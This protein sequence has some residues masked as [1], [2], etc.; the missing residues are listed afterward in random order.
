MTAEF[1]LVRGAVSFCRAASP[2]VRSLR[3]LL[4]AAA[5]ICQGVATSLTC[6]AEAAAEE[7]PP[8]AEAGLDGVDE[9]PAAPPAS[10]VPPA[11]ESPASESPATE[12]PAA[13]SPPATA[14][15][16]DP[17]SGQMRLDYLTDDAA[18]MLALRPQGFFG[19]N[20]FRVLDRL[21]NTQGSDFRSPVPVTQIEQLTMVMTRPNPQRPARDTN[22]TSLVFDINIVRAVQPV[23]WDARRKAQRFEMRP[24]EHQG[25]TYFTIPER[26]NVCFWP[27][28][29]RTYVVADEWTTKR[30]I[31]QSPVD[32]A[33][34]PWGDAWGQLDSSALVIAFAP[35]WAVRI[36]K[37]QAQNQPDL[38]LPG[39]MLEGL[40]KDTKSMLC[41]LD[42]PAGIRARLLLSCADD[43]QAKKKL[44]GFKGLIGLARQMSKPKPP[45]KPAP[46][47]EGEDAQQDPPSDAPASRTELTE[48]LLSSAEFE[49][50]GP[51]AL[52]SIQADIKVASAMELLTGTVGGLLGPGVS[53]AATDFRPAP[54]VDPAA[55][56]IPAGVLNSPALVKRRE[57]S[58]QQIAAV[59][60]ALHKYHD[61]TE[62]LPPRVARSP[63]GAPLLSWRVLILPDLGYEAL[64]NEFRLNEPW[65][66]QHNRPLAEKMPREFGGPLAADT[67]PGSPH[68]SIVALY[69]PQ[70]C[71]AAEGP[72]RWSDVTDG[73][74]FTL[75]LAETRGTTV[76]TCPDDVAV[77]EQGQP[78]RRLAG[79]HPGGAVIATAD[80]QPHFLTDAALAELLPAL[81]SIAGGEPITRER[82]GQP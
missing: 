40:L 39:S 3:Q 1:V 62:S 2:L 59:A 32:R 4:V 82:L 15:S 25:K 76:W 16:A 29:D 28:D 73:L 70:T 65:D 31:E 46:D 12:P 50:R 22:G 17:A 8:A 36:I 52:V 71:F 19:P 37:E 30:I 10:A 58:K 45:A 61:R 49:Q 7:S 35:E 43:A 42:A 77:D 47:S 67:Q 26:P 55:R 75:L 9:T 33:K 51:T 69:G 20:E 38:R 24:A 72:R 53:S 64:Y 18:A 66:S 78:Q 63:E 21:L 27:A 68:T 6:A 56:P 57:L 60:A 79:T 80:G 74:A 41:A 11:A 48:K 34:L 81:L 44:Q 5:V 13:E 54:S 14:E 23:D